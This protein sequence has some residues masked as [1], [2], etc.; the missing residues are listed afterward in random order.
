M[1]TPTVLRGDGMTVRKGP[2][3]RPLTER[4]WAKVEKRGN[5]E[6]WLWTG[7][8]NSRGY[9]HLGHSGATLYA[10]RLS[11]ELNIG[12]ISTDM[13]VCHRCDVR[14]CCNPAHLFLGTNSEN[15]AD[16]VAKGRHPKGER[17]SKKLTSKQVSE[18]RTAHG[19][20][21]EIGRRYGI[22]QRYVSD[23]RAG[24]RWA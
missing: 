15:T 4:F 2:A 16:K 17:A 23:I 19:S 24:R 20:Q 12:P 8:L 5:D 11:Y 1:R 3:R 14:N 7:A 9:G 13:Q 10:H 21:R 22:S 18:I 6:C